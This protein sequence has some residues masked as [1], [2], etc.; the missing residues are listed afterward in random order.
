[1]GNV[2]VEVLFLE[3]VIC[4][5]EVFVVWVRLMLFYFGYFR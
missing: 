1:M 4:C 3:E 2:E 5:V